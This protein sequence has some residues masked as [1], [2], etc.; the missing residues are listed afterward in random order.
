MPTFL[1]NSGLSDYISILEKTMEEVL[2]PFD[3]P[4]RRLFK[5]KKKKEKEGPVY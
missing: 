4:P 5:K 3:Y 1:N 2:K